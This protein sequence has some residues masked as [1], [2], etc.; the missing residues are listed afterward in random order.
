MNV[1][2]TLFRYRPQRSCRPLGFTLFV[3][4][5]NG[6]EVLIKIL[7]RVVVDFVLFEEAIELV[8]RG[9]AQERA[10]LVPGNAPLPI[11]FE[12]E[13]LQSG[14]GRF[15]AMGQEG[16]CQII[17][18]SDR[19][20]HGYSLS[21]TGEHKRLARAGRTRDELLKMLRSVALAG[22]PTRLG[23]GGATDHRALF[24]WLPINCT[25]RIIEMES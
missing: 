6:G 5:P 1:W 23:F 2:L 8:A 4:F 21:H 24:T 12:G 7:D 11:G 10:E 3:S 14:A 18:N 13:C 17:G 22:W 15:L 9:D 25:F 20:L 16:C 19:D